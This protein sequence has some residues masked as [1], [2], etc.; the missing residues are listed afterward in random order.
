MSSELNEDRLQVRERR[1]TGEGD[2]GPQAGE[3]HRVPLSDRWRR[4]RCSRSF[5]SMSNPDAIEPRMHLRLGT[6]PGP[7]EVGDLSAPGKVHT[8]K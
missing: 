4:L 2:P 5:L 1:R 7:S 3:R 8:E 6:G